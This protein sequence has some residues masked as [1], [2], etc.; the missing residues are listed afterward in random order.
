MTPEFYRDFLMALQSFSKT[1]Y[2]WIIELGENLWLE[3]QKL[4]LEVHEY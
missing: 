3:A 2:Q 1:Y 4:W